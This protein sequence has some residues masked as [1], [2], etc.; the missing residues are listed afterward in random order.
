MGQPGEPAR[1]TPGSGKLRDVRM[2]GF[3]NRTEVTVV[4]TILDGR[5]RYLACQAIG[6]ECPSIRW[7]GAEGTEISID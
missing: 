4:R 6:C 2:R 1:P 7:S 5:N 3:Q